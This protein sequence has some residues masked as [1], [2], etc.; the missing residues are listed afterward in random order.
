[1][2]DGNLDHIAFLLEVIH[3]GG[4]VDSHHEKIPSAILSLVS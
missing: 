2:N 1:M 4:S 3:S